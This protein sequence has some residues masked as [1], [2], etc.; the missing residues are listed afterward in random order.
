MLLIGPGGG[1]VEE[2]DEVA[3]VALP[4]RHAAIREA[5]DNTRLGPLLHRG[6]RGSR[7]DE[8]ALLDVVQRIAPLGL[9]L[10]PGATVDLNPV[11]VFESGRGATVLDPLIHFGLSS[12]SRDSHRIS[13]DMPW[14]SMRV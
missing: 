5:V 2:A 13:Y 4:A 11:R 1:Q 7:M 3:A 10:P 6:E 14:T 9:A 12:D 8:R